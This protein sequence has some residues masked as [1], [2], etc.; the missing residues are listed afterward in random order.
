MGRGRRRRRWAK[1]LAVVISNPFIVR[2]ITGALGRGALL[3]EAERIARTM[4][5]SPD[6]GAE[7]IVSRKYLYL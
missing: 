4:S 1:R 6:L 7:K 3:D 2:D 5:R